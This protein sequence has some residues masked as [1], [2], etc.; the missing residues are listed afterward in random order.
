MYI[1]IHTYMYIIYTLV[2]VTLDTGEKT[3][4]RSVE[5]PRIYVCFGIM[6]LNPPLPPPLLGLV[7]G[8]LREVEMVEMAYISVQY[9]C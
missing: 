5:V 1:Y 3:C 6:C 8:C 2:D 9:S 4:Q 7:C